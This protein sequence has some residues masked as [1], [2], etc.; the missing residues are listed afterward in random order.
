MQTSL[1]LPDPNFHLPYVQQWN[2][3]IE[4]KF[5]GNM[6]LQ[7]AYS[8]NRGIGL[9]FFSGINDARFPITSPL[10]TVDVGGR[11]FQPVVFDRVCKD[12][13]DPICVTLNSS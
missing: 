8:G 9:P 6:A 1:L 10:L 2:L 12:F 3:T 4:R 7:L 11:N 5:R 13:S